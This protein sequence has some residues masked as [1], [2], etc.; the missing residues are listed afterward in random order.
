MSFQSLL[1]PGESMAYKFSVIEVD[2]FFYIQYSG[3]ICLNYLIRVFSLLL[4]PYFYANM[5]KRNIIT[6]LIATIKYP[7]E[8]FAC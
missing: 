2:I 5:T 7:R 8:V 4:C 6:P 3:I 1:E